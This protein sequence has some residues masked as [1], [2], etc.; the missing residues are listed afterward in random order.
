MDDTNG[1][2]N[3]LKDLKDL[4]V[5][6]GLKSKTAMNKTA[7]NGSALNGHA[8]HP[9]TAVRTAGPGVIWRTLNVALRHALSLPP[10]P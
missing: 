1:S 6:K 4:T 2:L 10:P 7:M 5:P 9:K 3:G 8:A